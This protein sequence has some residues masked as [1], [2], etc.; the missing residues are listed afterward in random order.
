MPKPAEPKPLTIALNGVTH[1]VILPPRYAERRELLIL[2]AGNPWR[3]AAAALAMCCPSLKVKAARFAHAA[4]VTADMGAR[5][6]QELHDRGVEDM[7][8]FESAQP[9]IAA[10][11]ALSFPTAEEVA[12]AEDFSVPSG[13]PP[14]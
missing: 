11:D 6:W 14:T 12:A 8:M 13:A 7:A 3:G 5:A 9:I 10:L 4:G 2:A 1:A